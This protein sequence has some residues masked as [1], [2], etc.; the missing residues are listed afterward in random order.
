MRFTL[1]PKLFAGVTLLTP[2]ILTVCSAA[3]QPHASSSVLLA[4]ALSNGNGLVLRDRENP[5][6]WLGTATAAAPNGQQPTACTNLGVTCAE[7]DLTIALPRNTWEHPG[8]V[9]VAIRWAT[10]DNALDLFVYQHDA[11][12][13]ADVQVGNSSGILA[14]ISDSLLLRSAANGTYKVY[15]AL[16]PSNS[17]DASVPF[18]AEARVQY[19]PNV[20]PVRPLLPDLQFRPQTIVTFDTPFF[21][22]FGDVADPGD[23]CFHL[24]KEKTGR[25]PAF[26]SSRRSPTTERGRLSYDLPSLT[27][28]ATRRTMSSS[29]CI[30]ATIRSTISRT[31]Q[32][33]GG[34]LRMVFARSIPRGD[35]RSRRRVHFGNDCGP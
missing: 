34:H 6:F 16:D 35:R 26:D 22:F 18:E 29:E 25:K 21:P 2:L 10:D 17:S 9:Q 33:L 20:D 19:D 12:T 1:L 31:N 24:E 3:G 28:R 15:V 14:G 4:S 11:Q 32:G 13:G 23:S 8:G 30:S 5:I 7:F 27:V